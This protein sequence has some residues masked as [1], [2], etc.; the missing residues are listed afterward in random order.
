VQRTRGSEFGARMV[1]GALALPQS[2]GAWP[3]ALLEE[4]HRA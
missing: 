1:L 3:R 4:E 2:N